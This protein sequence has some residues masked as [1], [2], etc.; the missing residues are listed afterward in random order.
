[1]AAPQNLTIVYT[2]NLVYRPFIHQSDCCTMAPM[3]GDTIGH[4]QIIE[5]IG[6]GGMGAVYK[7][8]DTTLHRV[9]ITIL[10]HVHLYEGPL[11][12]SKMASNVLTKQ[13][14]LATLKANEGQL[15][16]FGVRR[17][18]LF[19]SF[20]R[21]C[22]Q[23]DSD[24]DLLVEF[25]PDQKSFDNFMQLAFFLEEVL[26]RRVELVTNASLSPYIGPHIL[27]ETEY[28]TFSS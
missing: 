14:I 26:K 25:E 27:E 3:I 23:D 12:E 8:E 21:D 6:E 1:M 11:G 18:G 9:W 2:T 10:F 15:R 22:Q 7:D 19:G 28:A 17:I 20:V 4:Y 16:A 24:V 13:K 5:K